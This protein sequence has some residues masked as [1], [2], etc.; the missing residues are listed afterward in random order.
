MPARLGQ[1]GGLVGSGAGRQLHH[2]HRLLAP[3]RAGPAHHQGVMHACMALQGIF[4][5]L[6]EY[7]LAAAV[8][9]QRIPAQQFHLA[10]GQQA[11]PVTGNGKSFAINGDKGLPGRRLVIKIA[12]RDM[13]PPGPPANAR[14]TRRQQAGAVRR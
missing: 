3:A 4:D 7:F 5:F 1:N 11:R 2:G 12:Q 14:M 6:D 8:D 9:G 10:T 13:A